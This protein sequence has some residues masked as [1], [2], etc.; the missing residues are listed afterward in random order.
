D[1]AGAALRHRTHGGC[2]RRAAPRDRHRRP[3]RRARGP[4]PSRARDRRRARP[5]LPRH[6]HDLP[7]SGRRHAAPPRSAARAGRDPRAH[8][9]TLGGPPPRRR[10]HGARPGA[11]PAGTRGARGALVNP[12][13]L[14][15]ALALLAGALPLACGNKTPLRPPE[16]I[17]PRPATSL[18]AR[19]TPTGVG[20]SWRRPVTYTGG[21]RMSDLGGFDIDRA[22]AGGGP[23]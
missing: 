17:Q 2:R 1:A 5:P 6:R 8:A 10:R 9:R 7:R 23:E 13:R 14:L 21:S 4:L 19:S 12:R 18:A 3:P 20:L 11:P 16:M 22:P 15:A